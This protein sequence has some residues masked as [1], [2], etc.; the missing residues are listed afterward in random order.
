MVSSWEVDA[1]EES[2]LYKSINKQAGINRRPC[3]VIGQE[4]ENPDY[5]E[6]AERSNELKCCDGGPDE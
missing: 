3:L 6:H 5:V 4:Q 2:K 1:G